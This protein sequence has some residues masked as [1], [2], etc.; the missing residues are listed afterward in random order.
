MKIL[1]DLKNSFFIAMVVLFAFSGA[2]VAGGLV[3]IEFDPA[4]FTADGNDPTEIDN[5][6]WPLPEGTTF[7]Y[8]AET[9][10][11]CEVNE[12]FVT[13]LKKNIVGIPMRVVLDQAWIDEECDG[14]VTDDDLLETTQDWYAQDVDGNI[15]YFGED[16]E[17]FDHDPEECPYP[18]T[19]G[20]WEHGQDVA[21]IG[22]DA[23]A[24][25][26]MLADPQK[27]DFYFQE[28]YEE[29]AEDQ[30]KVLNFLSSVYT[31]FNDYEDCL[32]TKEWTALDSGAVEHKF[33]CYGV[34]LVF[35]EE[36]H[37][38]TVDVQLVDVSD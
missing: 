12:I 21:G 8:L 35:I 3:E 23:Q 11:G 24:G 2:A 6:W 17:A 29:E 18:C 20:S 22:S 9:E 34:G 1:L 13:N 27:G 33:Y 38:K 25:I 7:S 26:I 16:T 30:G 28:F 5:P 31:D 19:E 36:L 10:D 4:N 14:E 15:W 32:K 37:G